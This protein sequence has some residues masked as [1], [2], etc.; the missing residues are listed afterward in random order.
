MRPES[1]N[2]GMLTWLGKE[3]GL[4]DS[5]KMARR[6]RQVLLLRMSSESCESEILGLPCH[7]SWFIVLDSTKIA[8]R[9][10]RTPNIFS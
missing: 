4:S 9:H 6:V 8:A 10:D 5:T 2:M 1:S 7:E 3:L